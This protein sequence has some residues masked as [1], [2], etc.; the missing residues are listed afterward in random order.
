MDRQHLDDFISYELRELAWRFKLPINESVAQW[1]FLDSLKKA[2]FRVNLHR[3][4]YQVFD[5]FEHAGEIHSLS[6]EIS[7]E[8][9]LNGWP[10]QKRATPSALYDSAY[11]VIDRMQERFRL[12]KKSYSPFPYDLAD[13]LFDDRGEKGRKVRDFLDASLLDLFEKYQEGLLVPFKN[14]R[15]PVHGPIILDQLM[16]SDVINLK[17]INEAIRKWEHRESEGFLGSNYATIAFLKDGEP[18]DDNHVVSRSNVDDYVW[19][20]YLLELVKLKGYPIKDYKG[21]EETMLE[22]ACDRG[23]NILDTFSRR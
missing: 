5:V 13:P 4:P 17:R 2:G 11:I 7:G 21:E 8:E 9:I 3:D 1:C 16:V 10:Q 15:A 23:W 22:V 18:L 19:G 14:L 12:G 6:A 20:N